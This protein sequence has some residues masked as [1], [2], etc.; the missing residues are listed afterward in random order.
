M[1]DNNIGLKIAPWIVHR[2]IC[3][4][5]VGAGKGQ[6]EDMGGE[7]VAEFRGEVFLRR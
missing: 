7:K 1:H 2:N 4:G 5:K 3:H 6:R